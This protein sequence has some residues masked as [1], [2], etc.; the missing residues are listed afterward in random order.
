M[1]V[2]ATVNVV[3]PNEN[4]DALVPESHVAAPAGTDVDVVECGTPDVFAHVHV[5]VSPTWIVVVDVPLP[6]SV[7]EKLATVTVA[8]AACASC[9]ACPPPIM[10][11]TS[12]SP[13]IADLISILTKSLLSH[14]I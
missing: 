11:A 2:P 4:G 14:V 13:P 8:P 5:T 7:N 3:G 9:R 10:M 6:P 1:Y 12:A